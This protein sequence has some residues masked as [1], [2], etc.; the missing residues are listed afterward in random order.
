[1][2]I[3]EEKPTTGS[4]QIT[5]QSRERMEIKGVT[6]VL[7]FDEEEIVLDTT[8]GNM[9]IE[10]NALHVQVLNL[11]QGIVCIIGRIDSLSYQST[12]V[13]NEKGGFWGRLLR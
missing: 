8:C 2:H 9:T 10:G 4:H 1:M 3:D 7:S 12:E 5:I 11:E 6:D 13:T